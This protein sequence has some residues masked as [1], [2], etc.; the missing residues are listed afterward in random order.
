M[1]KIIIIVVIFMITGCGNPKLDAPQVLSFLTMGSEL[2]V[3]ISKEPVRVGQAVQV[4]LG[5]VDSSGQIKEQYTTVYADEQGEKDIIYWSISDRQIALLTDNARLVALAAGK[6]TIK[7]QVGAKEY[8]R[9]LKIYTLDEVVEEENIVDENDEEEGLDED[10]DND[11]SDD[12]PTA[13]QTHAVDVFSFDPG[14]G[15]GFGGDEFPDVVLG[16][17]MGTMDVLSLGQFGEIVLDLGDCYLTDGPGVDLIVFENPF[18]I[19]GDPTDPYAE[20]GVVGVSTDGETFVEFE[21]LDAEYPFTGCAGW[22]VVYANETN[23]LDP[24]DPAE[25]GGDQ[26][27][28]ADIGLDQARY[29]RIRD[30]YGASLGGTSAGYDLDAISVVNGIIVEE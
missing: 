26:F 30:L 9:D 5:L 12:E 6:I 20:L 23:D 10:I 15:A 27:D 21:C 19:G 16:P 22:N 13:C 17:P 4:F 18:L 1:T 2:K 8:S 29:I 3:L 24:F 14:D 11:G 7:A 25:A 28:L